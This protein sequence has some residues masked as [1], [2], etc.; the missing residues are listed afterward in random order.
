MKSLLIAMYHNIFLYFECNCCLH[1]TVHNLVLKK[2]KNLINNLRYI[3]WCACVYTG[4]LY[5]QFKK[6]ENTET[7]IFFF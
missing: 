3:C 6:I 1:S 7:I 2:Y 5:G 4:V